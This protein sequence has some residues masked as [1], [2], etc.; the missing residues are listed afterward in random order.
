M[1]GKHLSQDELQYVID[2]KTAQ[3]Q[4]GIHKLEKQTTALR[5]ENK[6]RL[7]QMVE[8]EAKG[9]KETEQ[10]KN[11]SAVYRETG[12]Q[13]KKLTEKIKEQTRTLDTNVMTMSQL[14]NQA[15]SLQRELDNVSRTL[16]PE[17][18]NQLQGRLRSVTA[19][20]EELKISARGFKETFVNQST[21]NY[22]AGIALTKGAELVSRFF[23][24]MISSYKDL[25]GK[26][27][28]LAE[29]ADGITHAFE[30]IGSKDYLQSLRQATKGTVTDIELMKA[31]VQA[32]DFHIPLEDLGKYLAFAQ[33]KA[34]QTGQSL[35]Y[36]VNSI[37]TGLGRE[38][39]RI[40]DNL[41]LSATEISEKTK[42]TGDFMK[43]V[44]EIVENQL[45][46][47]G[48][49]YISAS[50]RAAQRTV[51]LENAQK[52]LGDALLPLKEEFSDTYGQI[53]ISI[54]NVTKYLI[55][56]RE[57]IYTVGKA[58]ALLIVTLIAY[59]AAQKAAY[60][61]SLRA[62]ATSKLK[63]AA[64]AVENT[65]LQLSILRH[66]VLNKTMTLSIALQK[67]FNVVLKLSPWGLIFG[68]I[69]LVV[70]ALLLFNKRTEEASKKTKEL[71]EAEKE[72]KNIKSDTRAE[73]TKD[74][75]A[76]QTF[77]GS[78][79]QE[80]DLVQKMNDKYGE[81]MGYY[82]S[83]KDWYNTLIRNSSLYCEQMV[84]EARVRNLANKAAEQREKAE[85]Y[86][87]FY[88][89]Q[90]NKRAFDYDVKNEGYQVRDP[91]KELSNVYEQLT[92]EAD[93]TES[94]IKI[95]VQKSY[96]NQQ[97]MHE[98][99]AASEPGNP[100]N[101]NNPSNNDN[102]TSS[103]KSS[104]NNNRQQ[105]LATEKATYDKGLNLL[106]QDLI[107]KVKTREEYDAAVQSLEIAHAANVLAIER[108]YTQKAKN[109]RIED[110]NEKKRIQLAQQTNE[111]QA[112]QAFQEKS[113]AARQ[114][115]FDALK[116][117]QEKG[118]T[119]E[120]KAE[121]DHQL[122][123]ASL[124]AFYKAS[125]DY[126]R[127]HGEDEKALT[128]AYEKAKAE[129][130]HKY[131][132]Q[133]ADEKFQIRSQAG[134][135]SQQEL[136]NRELAQLKEK[137]AKEGLS[138][139]EQQKA[140]ANMTHQFEED[141]LRIRQQYGV[142]TQ[143]ELFDAELAQL[144]AHL[145]A[146]MIS[147]EEYE[148]AVSNLKRDRWKA[149][150]D[151]YHDLFANAM[152][153]LQNAEIA[154]MEAKYDA[155][156]QAAQGS[157]EQVEKLEK[158]KA[159][160]KLNIQKK[161]ADVNFAIQASQIIVNTAVSVMKAFSDLG[162]IA[163]AISGALISIAGTAQLAV[164]NAERQKVKKMTL[165]G[166]GG[167]SASGAR[168]ATGLES[169]GVFDVEREQDGKTFRATYDPDRR[170]YIDR[171]TVLVGEGPVGHSKEWVASN[172]ALE[173]PTVAP[174]IDI[175][176]RA[177]RVGDIR[178]LDMRKLMMQRGFASGGSI[179]APVS[180][181]QSTAPATSTQ[182]SEIN[183]EFLSL[184]RELREKGIPAYVALDEFDAQQKIREQSRN[185]GKK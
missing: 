99:A 165:Q 24:K 74:I 108:D 160:E 95:L 147:E 155:E 21:L 42:K 28:E 60:L 84:I 76:L 125:L 4:Q 1:A 2:V 23:G 49:T 169:G 112:E 132:K 36:M 92:K 90:K 184:L 130:T 104:F 65:M 113:L 101:T 27:V 55:E 107:N 3:A 97:K 105:D 172:A 45:A 100:G 34:Q 96:D 66:A 53:Q 168:V 154:N 83:V 85:P 110:E 9:K 94:L 20:M 40:L 30:R 62:V 31:A 171:P 41:G 144:K 176:D 126:A 89:A 35:D 159:N 88:L 58:V 138:E 122:Q 173:N 119:D 78:K 139:E 123:L 32:K 68:G 77:K 163:G 115:Y 116:Q 50:D 52:E 162:P 6:Q 114:Q 11:L 161:Y 93:A 29:S 177:Q 12:Q 102:K 167:S 143:Q 61:W 70:G 121:A 26:S 79:Q 54:L 13:I 57:T 14:R 8:L 127:K 87:K 39:P 18:Y 157:A 67:A 91:Q 153:E 46:E 17:L 44:A 10:Y 64:V 117:L 22:M 174:V 118:M 133:K 180:P 136:F 140:I 170:G 106:K 181:A 73:L 164:A 43:A 166:A 158:E 141:K 7:R 80:L 120:Q 82:K 86:K 72:Y 152:K 135:V 81:S 185:I 156:I 63:S 59:A 111:Q 145:D 128:E 151:R 33:L 103:I 75:A 148:K 56:H 69:T 37:V 16:N 38:S 175:I 142:A 178:T 137:L 149:D 179:S 51:A 47:A 19:R 131:E 71:I 150:F 183:E 182:P 48:E 134:L 124:E 109:L 146:K 25:I 5:N 129:I 15:K 98:G